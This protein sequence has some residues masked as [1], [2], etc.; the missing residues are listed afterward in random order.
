[1]EIVIFM[2]KIVGILKTLKFIMIDVSTGKLIGLIL[3][4]IIAAF[5]EMLG[6][7]LMLPI[8]SA[9]L[10]P[11]IIHENELAAWVCSLFGIETH[12]QFT[13]LCIIALVGVFFIKNAYLLWENY[14]IARFVRRSKIKTQNSL[15][16]SYLNRPYEYYLSVKTNYVTGVL[17][18][19][20]N[21]AYSLINSLL[22]ALA[23]LVV[24]FV[25]CVTIFV[26]NPLM[27][28]IILAVVMVVLFVIIKVIRPRLKRAGKVLLDRTADRIKW[29]Y[30]G[31]NGIKDI[32][33][34][35][36]EAH[37]ESHF[38]EST[39]EACKAECFRMVWDAVPRKLIEFVVVGGMLVIIGI[40]VVNGKTADDLIPT[41]AA[42]AMAALKLLPSANSI[43]LTVN[44]IA[45]EMP[46]AN[47]VS[48]ALSEKQLDGSYRD[49]SNDAVLTFENSLEFRDI[50]YTYPGTSA[51]VLSNA[52][53][54]VPV[55]TSVGIV[56]ASGAGKS[57]AADI[58]LGLLEPSQ[59]SV[60]V[61]GHNIMDNYPRWLSMVGYIP[62]FIYLLNDTVLANVAF[63]ISGGSRDS[64]GT[65]DDSQKS[66]VVDE[67]RVWECLRQANL[68]TFIRSLPDGLYT[69]IGE[70]GIRLS[71]GQRQRI[72]IARA[73]YNN[74]KVL[75]FDEATSS[76]DNETEN[77]IIESINSMQGKK[78][79]IIIA[80]RLQTIESC[81]CVYRVSDGKIQRER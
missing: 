35:R 20:I 26:I 64:K 65:T 47:K 46:S 15:Y 54:S 36:K 81:D 69:D 1:M 79:M 78:T 41:L 50:S 76:L 77:Y 53:F 37:F 38:A 66:E 8:M 68:D 22:T 12:T 25:L 10:N 4:M 9:I 13:L 24:S 67:E 58:I 11:Q 60:L 44:S 74:P 33:I 29:T 40:M 16:C 2:K 55:N 32:K 45:F 56:G 31:I 19:D 43:V 72:G 61:D 70:R 28:A 75:I 80:H 59:G 30:Q 73:L 63:G 42:F 18:S 14:Y 48:E 34:S 71:G 23:D 17:T 7:S 57:T 6:V 3:L 62:Q 39:R 52:S 27:T 21:R 51:P 5:F 49:A